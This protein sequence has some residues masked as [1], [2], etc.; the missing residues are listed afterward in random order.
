MVNGYLSRRRQVLCVD[1]ATLEVPF[2][3]FFTCP[4]AE[5]RSGLMVLVAAGIRFGDITRLAVAVFFVFSGESRIGN[6]S[7]GRVFRQ[8][9]VIIDILLILIVGIDEH[10]GIGFLP[11]DI[12]ERVRYMQRVGL[13]VVVGNSVNIILFKRCGNQQIIAAYAGDDTVAERGVSRDSVLAEVIDIDRCDIL[14]RS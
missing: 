4:K 9:E 5:G 6:A 14:A 10:I 7:C 13:E 3:H 8:A 11:V 1:C 12:I 2:R